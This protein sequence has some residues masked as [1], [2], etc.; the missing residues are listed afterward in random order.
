MNLVPSGTGMCVVAILALALLGPGAAISGAQPA[1][2]AKP[3]PG[4]FK[5]EFRSGGYGREAIVNIPPAYRPDARLPLVLVMHGASGSADF[6]LHKDGWAKESDKEGFICVAPEGLGVAFPRFASN[7]R[8]NPAM[9]NSGQLNPGSP[10]AAVDDVAFI[11]QLLDEL[12]K[13]LPYD[14]TRVYCTGHSNGGGMTFRLA[15][16]IPERFAAVATVA[17]LV[18]VENP[19]PKK[20]LPTLYILGTKDPIMPMAGGEV[21]HPWGSRQNPPIADLLAKWADAIGCEKQGKTITTKGEM[22]TVEYPSKTKGGPALT[23]LFL[24][25]HGH[26]WPGAIRSLPESMIGPITSKIDAT[27]TIWQYF[28]AHAAK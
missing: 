19:R 7:A 2:P 24:E 18:A 11:R 14:E 6:A 27:D 16:E 10:R 1:L 13:K 3:Q 15:T 28:K 25:G 8:T 12:K 4:Q 9:W 22:R 21:K 17:G 23:V 26:H 5:I 20:A